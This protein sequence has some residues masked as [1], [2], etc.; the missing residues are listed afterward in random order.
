MILLDTKTPH[1]W[2]PPWREGEESPPVYLIRAGS[3]IEREQ[4]EAELAGEHRAARV[5]SFQLQAAFTKGVDAL[6]GED[7]EGAARLK[8]LVA[9]EGAL[10]GDEQLPDDEAAMLAGAREV[11]AEHYPAYHIL[12]AQEQRREA[13]APLVAFRR[14][15]VGWENVDAT[16]ARGID[17]RVTLAAMQSLDAFEMRLAGRTAYSMLYGGG[18][19]KNSAAL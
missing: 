1:R 10:E 18:Q 17:G 8:E 15:V 11:L 13:M 16:F 2:T 9:L 19:T 3:V 5:Y 14:F 4:V 12:R 6:L 7:P